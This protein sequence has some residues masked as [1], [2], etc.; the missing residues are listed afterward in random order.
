MKKNVMD[1]ISDR[2]IRREMFSYNIRFYLISLTLVVTSFK[3]FIFLRRMM[4]S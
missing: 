3:I 1:H 2:K 4:G